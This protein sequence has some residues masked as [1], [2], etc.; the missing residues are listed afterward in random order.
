MYFWYFC[1][2]ALLAVFVAWRQGQLTAYLLTVSMK[3]AGPTGYSLLTLLLMGSHILFVLHFVPVQKLVPSPFRWLLYG[4]AYAAFLLFGPFLIEPNT[5][6]EYR[7][8]YAL[9]YGGA[10][11]LLL[12]MIWGMVKRKPTALIYALADGPILVVIVLFVSSYLIG[13]HFFNGWDLRTSLQI[14]PF[15]EVLA[16]CV[17]L[18]LRFDRYRRDNRTLLQNLN[19][20]QRDIIL[21]QESERR[22]IAQDLHDD[23]GNTLAAAKGLLSTINP[24][25]LVRVELPEVGKAQSLID[26]AD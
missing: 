4:L 15:F 13:G 10:V 9:V 12:L 22:R 23:V 8:E 11:S 3:W 26:K 2:S 7:L 14:T 17:G 20:A 6:L 24:K 5:A 25:L 21:T 19:Q 18:V 1:Q 16:L